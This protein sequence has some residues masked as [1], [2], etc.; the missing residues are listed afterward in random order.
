MKPIVLKEVTPIDLDAPI[1]IEEEN[2][3]LRDAMYAAECHRRARYQLMDKIHIGMSLKEICVTVEDAVRYMLKDEK[4]NGAGFPVGVSL[5]DCA[6]HYSVNPGDEDIFLKEDDI[7]KVDFGTHVDGRIMDSAFTVCFNPKY[8]PLLMAA[9]EGTEKGLEC[10]GVD[11][12]V[13]DIG[14]EIEEVVSS[15]EVEV[16]GKMVPV[17]SV[18][19]LTGHSIEQ[20]K[21]HG[22]VA[23]PIIDNGDETKLKADM[24][25]ACETFVTT[26]NGVVR[27]AEN[28]SHYMLEDSKRYMV[29][30][31][32]SKKVLQAILKNVG[33]L[34]FSPRDID[35]YVTVKGGSY[36]FI[37]T[38]A[39]L[40]ILEA[41]PPL[42]D[43]KGSKV[44]QFEHTCYLSE[45][46]KIILT[47]GDDY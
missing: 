15:Y 8:E 28:C 27:D 1:V 44:A 14:K 11:V 23:I 47:R 18:K 16:D 24:F 26:G 38:L 41:Y 7:L 10:I 13:C 34:P 43:S 33:T 9:K 35:R 42:N 46:S 37:K 40:R 6:A 17:K 4:N 32:N 2:K 36:P 20:F 22:G 19:N 21:I 12:R 3:K 30:N 5:N 45:S 29:K 39:S 31:A 25:Y